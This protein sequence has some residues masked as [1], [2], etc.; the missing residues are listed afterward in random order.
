MGLTRLNTDDKAPRR[1]FNL[2]MY[3]PRNYNC[4]A[5]WNIALLLITFTPT[6]LPTC[7]LL[8]N[9]VI[10]QH[11]QVNLKYKPM[12]DVKHFHNGLSK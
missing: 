10:Q 7:C 3:N 12:Q 1:D 8:S 6:S 4:L 9:R 11:P 5:S 2:D